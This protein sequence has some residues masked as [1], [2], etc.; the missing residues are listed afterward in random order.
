[1][2]NSAFAWIE[3]LIDILF[4]IGNCSPGITLH[5]PLEFSG[6]AQYGVICVQPVGFSTK[7]AQPLQAAH[8]SCFLN[9]LGLGQL[10]RRN[11]LGPELL[12]FSVYRLFQLLRCMPFPGGDSNPERTAQFAGGLVGADVLRY[13]HIINQRSVEPRRFARREDASRQAKLRVSRRIERRRV[14]GVVDARQIHI[15][16]CHCAFDSIQFRCP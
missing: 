11:P 1:M 15:I 8:K 12:Q 7:C 10:L 13:L 3:V 9:S 5:I 14:P 2:Q 6:I 4:H 16:F